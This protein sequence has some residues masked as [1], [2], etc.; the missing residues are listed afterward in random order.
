[1]DKGLLGLTWTRASGST[2]LTVDF[3]F[4]ASN[5]NG[6]TWWD[7]AMISDATGVA[8]VTGTTVQIARQVSLAGMTHIQLSSMTNNDT[9]NDLTAVNVGIAIS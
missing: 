8:A 1:V 3:Y 5:D 2:S 4:Q 6:T 9:S 7:Y